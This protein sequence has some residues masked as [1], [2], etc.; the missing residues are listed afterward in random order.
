MCLPQLTAV[1]EVSQ[2]TDAMLLPT[3]LTSLAHILGFAFNWALQGTCPSKSLTLVADIYYL[4]FPNDSI[5][6]KCLDCI[7]N[8]GNFHTFVTGDLF[9]LASGGK[10]WLIMFV[11]PALTAATV[12]SF[13]AWRIAVVSQSRLFSIIVLN[14]VVAA[15]CAGIVGAVSLKR[16]VSDTA[17]TW[18]VAMN[19]WLWC[20]VLAD[21]MIAGFMVYTLRRFKSVRKDSN[22][23][24][25]RV[26]KVVIETG[27]LTVIGAVITLVCW[28]GFSGI[29]TATC[30]L[31]FLSKL[32]ANTLMITLNNRAFMHGEI[33]DV[34][35]R[36]SPLVLQ[37]I[38]RHTE[39]ASPTSPLT[40]GRHFSVV[41][42]LPKPATAHVDH[43]TCKVCYRV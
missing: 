10:M 12:Q 32:Y 40:A 42:D 33:S 31:L 19:V 17:V 37:M 14:V 13:Y 25:N 11:M 5:Y 16:D 3:P 38:S 39:H 18:D 21:S 29:I 24:I 27:C 4:C 28:L 2:T 9:P 1:T 23:L 15:F 35:I 7:D 20:S 26:I 8:F 22:V 43:E 6:R 34:N 36:R 30:P 41:V